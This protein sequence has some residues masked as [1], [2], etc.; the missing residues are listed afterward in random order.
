MATIKYCQRY[1]ELRLNIVTVD[2]LKPGKL[3][4]RSQPARKPVRSGP[5]NKSTGERE[6]MVYSFSKSTW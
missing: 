6:H 4:M 3:L 5:R 1:E 2:V